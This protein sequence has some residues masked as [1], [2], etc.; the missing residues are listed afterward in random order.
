MSHLYLFI[1]YLKYYQRYTVILLWIHLS[2]ENEGVRPQVKWQIPCWNLVGASLHWGPASERSFSIKISQL[3][4]SFSCCLV[5]QA[6]IIYSSC[7]FI[8]NISQLFRI[9]GLY[10][11]RSTSVVKNSSNRVPTSNSFLF[12]LNGGIH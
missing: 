3:L 7:S 1:C 10:V 12:Q 6:G 8:V 11:F 9:M 2:F 5:L 4:T